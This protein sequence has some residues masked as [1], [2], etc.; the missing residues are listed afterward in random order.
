M[1]QA[2]RH[3]FLGLAFLSITGSSVGIAACTSSDEGS[4][5]RV[6]SGTSL[7]AA[8]ND[9]GSAAP[10]D[11]A[12]E[13]MADSAV[14]DAS[15]TDAAD[16]ADA[17]SA[18]DAAD[19]ADANVSP[20]APITCKTLHAAQPGAPSGIYAIDL[21]GTGTAYPTINVYCDMTFDGGGWTMIQSFTGANSPGSLTGSED[22]GVLVAAPE[23]GKLGGLASW[24]VKELAMLSTQVHIR[25]SFA[26]DAGADG[27]VWVTTREP[28]AGQTTN[29]M[30]NLRNLNVL[31]KGTDGGFSDWTGPQATAARLSWV[32][33]YGGGPGTCYNPVEATK[34]PSIYWACGNFTSMNLYAPQGLC[35]WNYTGGGNEPMEVFVR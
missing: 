19:A 30:T 27:G 25:N 17:T 2:R 12:A 29:A 10:F 31:T 35:S 8:R 23:P 20:T 28:D 34:Y 33:L 11:A 21:D 26:S 9:T 24:V 15:G 22:A 18:A 13:A 6:D 7:D 4:S 3:A 5:P 1:I 32:P 14:I 16:A